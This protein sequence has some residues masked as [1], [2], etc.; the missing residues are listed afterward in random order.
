MTGEPFGGNLKQ[1]K[2]M[3]EKQRELIACHE[4][5][6]TK[7]DRRNTDNLLVIQDLRNRNQILAEDIECNKAQ[8]RALQNAINYIARKV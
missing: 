8:L 5:E 3:I 2:V 4:A 7:V 1:A 6:I